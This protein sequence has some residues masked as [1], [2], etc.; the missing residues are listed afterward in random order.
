MHFDTVVHAWTSR[1]QV[2]PLRLA[3]GHLSQASPTCFYPNSDIEYEFVQGCDVFDPKFN[4]VS[5]GADQ[6]IYYPYNSED[7][8]RLTEYHD[9]IDDLIYGDES[10]TA[11]GKLKVSQK[12]SHKTFFQTVAPWK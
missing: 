8:K 1:A 4:I 2:K 12:K 6:S 10:K 3:Q 5:P 7:K 9:E 11:V